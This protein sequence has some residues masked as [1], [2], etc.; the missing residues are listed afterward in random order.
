MKTPSASKAKCPANLP[1][2]RKFYLEL[3]SRISA[4]AAAVGADDALTAS[5]KTAVDIYLSEGIAPGG[6]ADMFVRLVFSILRPEIDKAIDRS[7]KA[8]QRA[9]KR[10]GLAKRSVA[11]DVATAAI[12]EESAATA[13]T[14]PAKPP[15]LNRRERRLLE[16]Q[17]KRRERKAARQR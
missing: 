11:T 3:D 5:A 2:S 16:Q 7:A 13:P 10:K 15:L 12:H 4:A 17:R 9:G 8:R 6:D 14:V 1:V